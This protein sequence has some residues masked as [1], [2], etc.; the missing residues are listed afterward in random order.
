MWFFGDNWPLGLPLLGLALL[1]WTWRAYGRDPPTNRS[2]KPEYA[3]PDGII[4]A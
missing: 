1:L 4:P 2:I 3:P